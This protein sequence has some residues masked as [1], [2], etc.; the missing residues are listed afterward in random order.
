[1]FRKI[2]IP[3]IRMTNMKSRFSTQ[4]QNKNT[5][6]WKDWN[7]NKNIRLSVGAAT[8][9]IV[10]LCLYDTTVIE[11]AEVNAF[12]FSIMSGVSAFTCAF[13]FKLAH[14]NPIGLTAVLSPI[15]LFALKYWYDR[16][17]SKTEE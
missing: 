4:T 14:I 3:F 2:S 17:N 13:L 15:P 6:K 5:P 7:H 16:R 12:V 8:G 11:C 9:L 10:N 1:M